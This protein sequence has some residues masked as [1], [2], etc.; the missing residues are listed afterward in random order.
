MD[1]VLEYYFNEKQFIKIY[2]L[3]FWL[4]KFYRLLKSYKLKFYVNEIYLNHKSYKSHWHVIESIYEI[5]SIINITSIKRSNR[6]S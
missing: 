3:F 4:N 1:D 5:V 6:A 2:R